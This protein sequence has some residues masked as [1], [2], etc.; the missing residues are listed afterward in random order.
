[1]RFLARISHFFGSCKFTVVEIFL[2]A[3]V[4]KI[5]KYRKITTFIILSLIRNLVK[6]NCNVDME[7][8]WEILIESLKKPQ[9]HLA[10]S[11]GFFRTCTGFSPG[12]NLNLHFFIIIILITNSCELFLYC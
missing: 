12:F 6:L 8:T 10:V 11:R 7:N 1:L 4:E 3:L 5:Q 2:N 9:P